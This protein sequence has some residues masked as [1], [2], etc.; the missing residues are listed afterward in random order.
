MQVFNFVDGTNTRDF[1]II[2]AWKAGPEFNKLKDEISDV[3][4]PDLKNV[5][6]KLASISG[7]M[8][9]AVKDISNGMKIDLETA[10]I[11]HCF[12]L[13]LPAQLV[14][15]LNHNY[16]EDTVETPILSNFFKTK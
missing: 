12:V 9:E 2:K 13:P 7:G 15:I 6:N 8:V 4:D 3:I 10:E 1:I 11:T 14:D 5:A 16:S